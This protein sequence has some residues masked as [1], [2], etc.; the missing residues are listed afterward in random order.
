MSDPLVGFFDDIETGVCPHC[1]QPLQR[2]EKSGGG[3]RWKE[4]DM[5]VWSVVRSSAA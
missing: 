5:Y 2:Q 4:V 1:K 3:Q